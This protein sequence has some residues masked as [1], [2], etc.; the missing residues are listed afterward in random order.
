MK[1]DK[2]NT[3]LTVVVNMLIVLVTLLSLALFWMS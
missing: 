2:E 3:T 1:R